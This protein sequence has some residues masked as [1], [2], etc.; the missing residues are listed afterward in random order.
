[1]SDVDVWPEIREIVG[2]VLF[3][4]KQPVTA[5][6]LLEVFRGAAEQFGG[7]AKDF[8]EVSE[9][10]IEEAIV[11]L[12]ETLAGGTG[13]RVIAVAGGYRM[14]NDTRCGPWL[15]QYLE[16]GKPNRLS[17]P[18]LETLAIIAYRQPVTRAQ[19]ES[20]RGVAVDQIVRNLLDLQLIRAVGR[21]ELPGRPWLFGTTQ[22]FLEHFGLGRL[23]ELPGVDE[24]REVRP[25]EPPAGPAKT[26]PPDADTAPADAVPADDED[27]GPAL[28]AGSESPE[29]AG[30]DPE[31]AADEDVPAD[32]AAPEPEDERI[33]LAEIDDEPEARGP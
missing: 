10:D 9:R 23:D 11:S 17:P 1:M 31:A 3:A 16:K 8:A 22:R 2:A 21:S 32:A 6:R 29:A 19:I 13:L 26:T 25:S 33:D 30:A 14:E 28:P 20:V 12:R 18:A 7:A 5:A 4:A 15:R 24:L 27:A